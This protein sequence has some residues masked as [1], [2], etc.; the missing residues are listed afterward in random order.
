MK[1]F[2]VFL[3]FV[4][5]LPL[6][7]QQQGGKTPYELSPV[8]FAGVDARG[9]AVTTGGAGGKVINVTDAATLY[10]TLRSLRADKNPSLTPTI[11]QVSGTINAAGDKMV[12][13]KTNANI[14]LIG[15]GNNTKFVGFGLEVE[16]SQNIII[17]N[18]EFYDCPVDGIDI[19]DAE[20]HHIWVDHC[21]FSD[22]TSIDSTGSSHDGLLDVKREATHV[23]VSWCH[24][25]NHFKTCLF[26]HSDGRPEDSVMCGTY[27]HN[28]FERTLERHPRARY[29]KVH[30]LN[31]FEDNV[32]HYGIRATC[33]AKVL[34]EGNYFLNVGI[35]CDTMFE[36]DKTFGE[37]VLKDNVLVGSGVPEHRGLAFNPSDYYSYTVDDANTIPDLLR[38]YAGSGKVD[39]SFVTD[40]KERVDGSAKT[41]VLKQNYPN[42]FN[43]STIIRWQLSAG[44]R[45]VLNV[46][47]V[48]GKEVAT[49]V[50]EEQTAGD[51]YAV[52]NAA[53]LTSGVYICKLVAG[54]KAKTMKMILNK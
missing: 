6:F 13:F 35:P 42:P 54:G 43:P 53:S 29:G 47:D 45:V 50:N 25:S 23:T 16:T 33:T 48:L 15:K 22:G 4:L 44:S 11:I 17:R 28:W 3:C 41:L 19:R 1:C 36:D 39:F 21:T 14:T 40:V 5:L 26:G 31:N 32:G 30:V 10:S 37:I 18:I 20:T 2:I 38:Q 34:A 46:Y 52:F 12:Y 7:A 27:H 24:F 51:H 49:L 9:I 8:G